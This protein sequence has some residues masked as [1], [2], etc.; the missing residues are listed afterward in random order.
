M[1]T[2]GSQLIEVTF[3]V[4]VTYSCAPNP[5]SDLVYLRFINGELGGWNELKYQMHPIKMLSNVGTL[6]EGTVEIPQKIVNSSFYYLYSIVPYGRIENQVFEYYFFHEKKDRYRLLKVPDKVDT[7]HR[8]DGLVLRE[9]GIEYYSYLGLRFE[10]KKYEDDVTAMLRYALVQF[11]PQWEGVFIDQKK[12]VLPAMEAMETVNMLLLGLWINYGNVMRKWNNQN[13]KFRSDIGKTVF[14]L[15]Q[16]HIIEG[17]L[18]QI[19]AIGMLFV[20][21]KFAV[22]LNGP[23]YS[24]LFK[25]L[26][27]DGTHEEEAMEQFD[28]IKKA[29]TEEFL[30]TLLEKLIEKYKCSNNPMWLCC[31]PLWHFV[32]RRVTPFERAQLS[33]K[34]DQTKPVWWGIDGIS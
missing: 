6:Y 1:T 16:P 4:I 23:E 32:T 5:Y 3:H 17:K 26:I 33:A 29:F 25:S 31:L 28:L 8:Y 10:S 14:D 13:D 34:H 22:D 9:P 7:W 27:F 24:I 21:E 19:A 30:K 15:L 20:L 2:R 11:F 18:S 12:A